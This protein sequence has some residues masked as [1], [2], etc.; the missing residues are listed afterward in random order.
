MNAV[1]AVGSWIFVIGFGVYSLVDRLLGLPK[2]KRSA[3]LTDPRDFDRIERQQ[4]ELDSRLAT[5]EGR[6][7]RVE[8]QLTKEEGEQ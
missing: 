7:E 2:R 5:L 6:L 4:R 1:R 8:K 3:P